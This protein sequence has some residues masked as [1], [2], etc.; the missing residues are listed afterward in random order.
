MQQA[1]CSD[2]VEAMLE[3]KTE[4]QEKKAHGPGQHREEARTTSVSSLDRL[5]G[6]QSVSQFGFDME[7]RMQMSRKVNN[8][9]RED[10]ELRR[11]HAL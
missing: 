5:G 10:H 6:T 3:R 11:R 8:R 9:R 1:K 7:S 2:D 4:E